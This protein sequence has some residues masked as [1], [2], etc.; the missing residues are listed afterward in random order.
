MWIEG[1]RGV[2]VGGDTP[3]V[4]DDEA[5]AN[6][7]HPNTEQSSRIAVSEMLD[8][9]LGAKCAPRWGTRLLVCDG[10]GVG[11]GSSEWKS[12]FLRSA[13]HKG[14][15]SFGRNDSSWVGWSESGSRR[16]ANAH[17]CDETA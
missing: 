4:S 7:G 11:G 9:T 2:W 10:S 17:S 1:A 12:R 6:M 3:H 5:V 14:V 15:S 8:P 13:A 16:R